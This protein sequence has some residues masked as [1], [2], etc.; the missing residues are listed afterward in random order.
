MVLKS[1]SGYESELV[2][3]NYSERQCLDVLGITAEEAHHLG[4]TTLDLLRAVTG[5]TLLL[6][7]KL[8]A[9]HG[10]YCDQPDLRDE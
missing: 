9:E 2:C 3:K 8:A 4:Y 6:R 5:A 10:D 7:K 1:R